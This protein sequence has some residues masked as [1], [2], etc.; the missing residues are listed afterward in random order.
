[1]PKNKSDLNAIASFVAVARHGGLTKAARVTGTARATLGRHLAELEAALGIRLVQRTTRRFA[2]TDAGTAF[3]AAAGERLDD[4]ARLGDALAPNREPNGI[5]RLSVPV[6]MAQT[7]LAPVLTKFVAAH[8]DVSLVVHS[9]NQKVDLVAEGFDLAIRAGDPGPETN[10]VRLLHDSRTGLFASP[11]Y[12]REHGTP[13]RPEEVARHR[14][15]ACTYGAVTPTPVTWLFRHGEKAISVAVRPRIRVNDPGA[16][17]ALAIEG[18]GLAQLPSFASC[19]DERLASV[20]ADWTLP[21]VPLRVVLATRRP[22]SAAA[23]A[24]LDVLYANDWN[25]D[26]NAIFRSRS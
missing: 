17:Y 11:D 14:L 19:Q 26:A 3:A 25:T 7:M 13:Q 8:P 15:V 12:L 6:F 24:L 5:V 2:L 4:I 18:A 9:G 1:M 22:P 16:A 23:R 10:V 20:L 21:S